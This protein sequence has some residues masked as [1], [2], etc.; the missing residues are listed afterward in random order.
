M[1]SLW[2]VHVAYGLIQDGIQADHRQGPSKGGS[3]KTQSAEIMAFKM[4]CSHLPQRTEMDDICL[5]KLSWMCDKYCITINELYS[6]L[7]WFIMEKMHIKGA[8]QKAHLHENTQAHTHI[9][10]CIS[11]EHQ[12]ERDRYRDREREGG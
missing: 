12:R 5:V 1:A 7:E 6:T 9:G 4:C 3:K 11:D 2:L 10:N 8:G